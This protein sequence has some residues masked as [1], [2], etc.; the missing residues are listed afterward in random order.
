MKPSG[1]MGEGFAENCEV[2]NF[3][4]QN[5]IQTPSNFSTSNVY[6]EFRF[7]RCYEKEEKLI[8][9]NSSE[10]LASAG[11]ALSNFT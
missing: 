7:C 4:S 6:K 9:R 11:T 2:D 8:A 5:N 3:Q 10:I 1:E